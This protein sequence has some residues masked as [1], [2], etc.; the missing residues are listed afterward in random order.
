MRGSVKSHAFFITWGMN[1]IVTFCGH[2]D[3]P[4]DMI[5][6]VKEKV[7]EIA[8]RLIYEKINK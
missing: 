4:A 8:E 6:A 1:M 5:G 2:A 7:R 3:I